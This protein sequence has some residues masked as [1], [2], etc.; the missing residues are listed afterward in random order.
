MHVGV[1]ECVCEEHDARLDQMQASGGTA[2]TVPMPAFF[3][4]SPATL[5]ACVCL[6]VYICMYVDALT[7]RCGYVCIYL[8]LDDCTQQKGL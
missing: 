5:T 6:C 1:C 4:A 3:T 7:S 8:I 2:A